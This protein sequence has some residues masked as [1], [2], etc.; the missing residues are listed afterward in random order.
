MQIS[1][2]QGTVVFINDKIQISSY[3][4]QISITS[5][6]W[7]SI[8]YKLLPT[9]LF[10]QIFDIYN[11]ESIIL[12]HNDFFEIGDCIQY[13]QDRCMMYEDLYTHT[14]LEPV[15]QSLHSAIHQINPSPVDK[16]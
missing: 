16:F 6:S 7:R 10:I 13:E 9:V 11:L 1:R 12:T 4:I 15:V 3:F 5:S 8:H 14:D 2:L